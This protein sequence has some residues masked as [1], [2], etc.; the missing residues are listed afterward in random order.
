MSF[1]SDT[2]ARVKPS[3]TIAV[4]TLA[5]E[6]KAAG[7]DVIG[8][9]AGEPDFDTP[10]NIKAAAKAAI[11]A[12]KTKYTAPDG[13]PELK[14]AICDKFAREN[15]LSYEPKQISVGTGG[16]QILYNALMATLNPGDEVIIPAP[17]WV[18]Y[19]DMVLMAG[20]EPVMV[21]CGAETEYK[22]TPEMLE[23]A[24]T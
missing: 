15:G 1:L 6:L 5:A 19:P 18:S 11:N 12:G 17:Y 13:I 2:L 7:R 14:R 3:P 9:G 10:D 20:G 21:A 24:N 22:M 8:L 4:T 16:K 23:A